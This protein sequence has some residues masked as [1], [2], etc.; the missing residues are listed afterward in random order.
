[1]DKPSSNQGFTLLEV[2]VSLGLLVMIMGLLPLITVIQNS[3]SYSSGSTSSTN[4]ALS[5]SE[6]LGNMDFAYLG[7]T[8]ANSC[9]DSEGYAI[10][11]SSNG[12]CREGPL[13]QLGYTSL[14]NTSDDDIYFYYRYSV[15][16]TNSA[17][18]P[19]GYTGDICS[20]PT[21]NYIGGPVV[22]DLNC[23]AASYTNQSKEIKI[24]VAYRDRRGKCKK[25]LLRSWKVSY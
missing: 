25:T 18:L 19:G 8:P 12:I 23:T 5:L 16:C 17:N 22:N 24:M 13:N 20:L 7:T 1:M 15:V 4:I 14:D 9:T 21:A 3:N 11:G 2:I 6:I 10:N